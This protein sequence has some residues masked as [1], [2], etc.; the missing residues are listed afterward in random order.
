MNAYLATRYQLA[1]LAGNTW[2]RDA[3]AALAVWLLAIRKLATPP[4]PLETLRWFYLDQ[5]TAIQ[6]GRLK[7]PLVADRTESLPAVVDR[8]AGV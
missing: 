2:C 1:D 3:N 5:L 8:Y 6:A 7:V 4:A